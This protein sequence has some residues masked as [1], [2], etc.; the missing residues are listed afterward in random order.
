MNDDI[1]VSSKIPFGEVSAN[2]DVFPEMKPE[3]FIGKPVT[4]NFDPNKPLGIVVDA[5][6][7]Q[8]KEVVQILMKLDK[9]FTIFP[10]E[11]K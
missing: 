10:N 5:S 11:P 8:D 3:M 2:G 1:Y 6:I 7:P 9:S 4:L